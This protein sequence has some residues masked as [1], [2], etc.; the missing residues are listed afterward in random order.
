MIWRTDTK[1][2]IMFIYLLNFYF[3]MFFCLHYFGFELFPITSTCELRF[4]VVVAS[5]L[6]LSYNGVRPLGPIRVRMS[7]LIKQF[8]GHKRDSLIWKYFEEQAGIRSIAWCQMHKAGY[9]DI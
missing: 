8:T 4:F 9:A 5:V 6:I 3:L 1:I 7:S 2:I